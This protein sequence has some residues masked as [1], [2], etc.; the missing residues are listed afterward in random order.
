MTYKRS[1]IAYAMDFASFLID[2]HIGE[3]INRIILFGSIARGDFTKESDVDIFVDA[4]EEDEDEIGKQLTLY[5]SSQAQNIW[6]QKGITNEISLKVGN[7]EHWSLKRSIISSGILLYGKYKELP[8]DAQYYLLINLDVRNK[9]QSQQIKLW[10]SLYGYKQ[11][12]GKKVYV[13]KGLLSESEGK[14][15]GKALLLVPM[16]KRKSILDLLKERKIRHRLYELWSD[17]F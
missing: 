15:I 8:R 1:H 17:A 10:R 14:K 12:I 4:P 11:K 6:K 7:L 2:S 5:Q 13:S 16:E 3:K 9:K